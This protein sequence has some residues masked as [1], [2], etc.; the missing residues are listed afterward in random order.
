MNM[1]DRWSEIGR[2]LIIWSQKSAVLRFAQNNRILR[3][4]SRT[5]ASGYSRWIIWHGKMRNWLA[6]MSFLNLFTEDSMM[7]LFLCLMF[8]CIGPLLRHFRRHK[9]LSGFGII[10]NLTVNLSK[11]STANLTESRNRAL[12]ICSQPW[13]SIHSDIIWLQDSVINFEFI[14][15]LLLNSETIN[16]LS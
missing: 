10:K 8:V 16:R 7:V 9:K 2:S 3:L 12:E 1:Q 5:I 15:S 11:N 13:L 4:G 14:I 6:I